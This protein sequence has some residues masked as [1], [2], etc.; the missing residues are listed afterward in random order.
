MSWLPAKHAKHDAC[1]RLRF[2]T[3]RSLLAPFGPLSVVLT[4]WLSRITGQVKQRAVA[5]G[6]DSR[7]PTQLLGGV[8]RGDRIILGDETLEDG[9]KVRVAKAG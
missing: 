2:W 3:C 4:L 8:V 1:D 6:A 9:D 5:V 7:G